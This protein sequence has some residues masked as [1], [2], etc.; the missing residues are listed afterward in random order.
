MTSNA[1]YFAR[2]EAIAAISD[3]ML[4]AARE[5]LWNDLV[6]LQEEYRRLVDGLKHAE[7]GVKLDDAERTRKYEL[8]RRILAD[9][10][11]IRDLAN[12]RMAK[13]SA[14]FAAT[15]PASVLKELYQAR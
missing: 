2:Y 12:P 15:C 1:Q 13:L 14:L 5:A 3:R 11:A 6:V 8:I 4:V 9:D 10:A 7:E